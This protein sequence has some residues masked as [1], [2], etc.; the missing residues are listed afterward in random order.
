MGDAGAIRQCFR[1]APGGG[2]DFG[3]LVSS[4]TAAASA[5]RLSR[6]SLG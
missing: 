3:A 5:E 4:I 1:F 6:S 2:F